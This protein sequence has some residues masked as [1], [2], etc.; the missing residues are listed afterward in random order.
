MMHTNAIFQAVMY[1]EYCTL[2]KKNVIAFEAA[3]GENHQASSL[4]ERIVLS[5]QTQQF[6]SAFFIWRCTGD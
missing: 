6:R 5:K 2:Y 1:L 3:Q 4:D